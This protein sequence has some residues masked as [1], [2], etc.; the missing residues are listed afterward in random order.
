MHAPTSRLILRAEARR[1]P[2]VVAGHCSKHKRW[3]GYMNAL[4]VIPFPPILTTNSPS[5]GQSASERPKRRLFAVSYYKNT[6]YIQNRIYL[7][8]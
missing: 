4:E 6:F 7:A 2:A 3:R 8:G 5:F 1:Q